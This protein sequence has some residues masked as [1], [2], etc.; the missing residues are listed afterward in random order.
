MASVK[1]TFNN[2][3]NLVCLDAS[4]CSAPFPESEIQKF[5][6]SKTFQGLAKLRTDHEIKQVGFQIRFH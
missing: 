3:I 1:E 6:D 4:G 2:R 5:L